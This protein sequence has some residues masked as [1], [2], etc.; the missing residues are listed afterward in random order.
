MSEPDPRIEDNAQKIRDL[1]C[2]IDDLK[3]WILE[4]RRYH[5]EELK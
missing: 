5:K 4:H 1:E 2:D 3:Q